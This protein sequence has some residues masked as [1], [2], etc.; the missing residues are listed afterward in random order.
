MVRVA[1]ALFWIWMVRPSRAARAYLA[2]GYLC[3]LCILW[4]KHWCPTLTHRRTSF[5]LCS[6]DFW[7]RVLVTH[8]NYVWW[9]WH[10]N[11]RNMEEFWQNSVRKGNLESRTSSMHYS[12]ASFKEIWQRATS[13]AKVGIRSITWSLLERVTEWPDWVWV[14]RLSTS[15]Q[16]VIPFDQERDFTRDF[17][18]F[19]NS[20]TAILMRT[21][22]TH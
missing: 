3:R 8:Q 14:T 19:T 20:L 18:I 13:R 5:G 6:G 15:F 12:A 16:C 11:M 22:T 2:R 4:C 9:L 7:F 10:Q 21:K 17:T 1:K